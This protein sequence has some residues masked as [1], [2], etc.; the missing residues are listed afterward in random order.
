MVIIGLA[1]GIYFFKKNNNT[2]KNEYI[3]SRTS[4]NEQNHY[5]NNSNNNS[6]EN[7]ISEN[8]SS[9][10][11]TSSEKNTS[12]NNENKNNVIE[13]TQN[14]TGN[15]QKVEEEISSFS[16]KI[17]NKESSRQNNVTLTCRSLNGTIVPNGSTFSFCN[18]LG[19]A[20]PNQGYQKADVFDKDGNKV[21]GLGGGKCQVSTTLYNAILKVPSLVVTERHP[22]SNKVPYIQTG[23]DAAVSYGSYDLKFRN[24][25]GFDVKI[26]ADNNADNIIITL[27]KLI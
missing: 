21:Q 13:I 9:E 15:E 11:N 16:T 3:S 7:N 24:D 26:K 8:L 10:E 12:Q 19:P 14:D 2:N 4:A 1:I 22:H 17:Y 5:E 6:I 25:T 18:T 20:T 23:K 27:Y